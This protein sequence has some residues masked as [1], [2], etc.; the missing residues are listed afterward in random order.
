MVSFL[1]SPALR[2]PGRLRLPRRSCCTGLKCCVGT[3]DQFFA[4]DF[5][6][7]FEACTILN[8]NTG[9][10]EI[11]DDRSVLRY[12]NA[13]HD[14]QIALYAAMNDDFASHDF[15]VQCSAQADGQLV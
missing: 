3:S 13:V 14:P 5:N 11:A 7:A 6:R 10:Y 2:S 15:R 4:I 1:W 8:Q 9:C 12:L